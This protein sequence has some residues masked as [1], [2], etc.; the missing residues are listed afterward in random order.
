MPRVAGQIDV[1]KTEAILDAAI[2]VLSERGL[3]A[4]MEEIARRAGVSKQTIYNHYGSKAELIRAMATRRVR[5][6]TAP[7][8]APEAAENPQEALAAYAK[9]MLQGLLNPQSMTIFRL[10]VASVCEAP[11]IAQALYDAGPQASRRRL[12]D[13]LALEA[14][15]GRLSLSDALQAAEFFS[16]MVI[17]A[18]Q[19]AG[20][21]G[22][23][24]SLTQAEIDRIAEEAS[25]RFMR[26]YAP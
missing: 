17:S 16:G 4:P 21:L 8:D 26:A 6:I 14:D 9:I 24:K 18:R 12:A 23:G 10:A 1:A 7:L 11:D 25:A 13:F 2:A 5:E 20:L 22:A 3:S 15:A 19:V